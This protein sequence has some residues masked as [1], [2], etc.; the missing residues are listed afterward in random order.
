MQLEHFGD[1]VRS[2]DAVLHN[3]ILRGTEF[4]LI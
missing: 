2:H 1:L 4:Y 3:L